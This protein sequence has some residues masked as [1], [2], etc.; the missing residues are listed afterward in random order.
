MICL[1]TDILIAF[2]RKKPD[3]LAF[4]QANESGG[5]ATTSINEFELLIGAKISKKR[6]V[7]LLK[8][9]DLVS[10]IT[11]LNLARKEIEECS[12]I[13]AELQNRGC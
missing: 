3:A 11:I 2:L 6:A 5:L 4:I 10:R 9:Q 7:N 12:D 13:Y 1:D 8:V